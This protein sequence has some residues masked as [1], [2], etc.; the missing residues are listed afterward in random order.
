MPEA[1]QSTK[2]AAATSTSSR[3]NLNTT[4]PA[5]PQ[6]GNSAGVGGHTTTRRP[7]HR[8]R[9]AQENPIAK[10]TYLQCRRRAGAPLLLRPLERQ[11]EETTARGLAGG[12]SGEEPC[13]CLR[14]RGKED[15]EGEDKGDAKI[16]LP[17]A[18]ERV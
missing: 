17:A 9:G 11:T 8:R 10:P 3:P 16:A 6:E 13:A 15:S 7:L 5:P 1:D 14:E 12:P 2:R 18:A 4:A